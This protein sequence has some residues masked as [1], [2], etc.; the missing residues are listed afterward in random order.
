[1][2]GIEIGVSDY[3]VFDDA[4]SEFSSFKEK[5]ETHKTE[6]KSEEDKLNSE[7]VFLGP[8]CDNIKETIGNL[9]KEFDNDS[10]RIQTIRN[11]LNDVYTSYN[12]ADYENLKK[13][14]MV[15]T[16]AA[17]SNTGN[18]NQDY[19]YNYLAGKGYNKAAICGILAN[20]EYESNFST[21]CSG[22]SGS[23]YGICQWHNERWT[24]LKNYC[25]ERNLDAS[26][27]EAQAEYLDYEL[28]TYYPSLYQKLKNIPDTKQ[29]SY[30]A[31]YAWTIDFERPK[32]PQTQAQR[33]GSSASN[34][35]WESYT[36]T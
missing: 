14:L 29:G 27:I 1:M 16:T 5:I 17:N 8:I 30:D 31:A 33:R 6:V 18:T 21:S 26:T 7:N 20:I 24:R 35:Y 23:S 28:Q 2:D 11:Y 12:N 4:S 36:R 25:S 34:N 22:D 15:S 9:L 10:E 32:N 19:L 3:K 13:L